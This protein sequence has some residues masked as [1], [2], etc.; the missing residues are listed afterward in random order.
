MNL[1]IKVARLFLFLSLVFNIPLY[2]FPRGFSVK[3]VAGMGGAAGSLLAAGLM[4]I[5]E[6]IKSDRA[7]KNQSEANLLSDI[8]NYRMAKEALDDQ[9][10][11]GVF[12]GIGGTLFVIALLLAIDRVDPKYDLGP[13]S[14]GLGNV[15]LGQDCLQKDQ[16][17]IAKA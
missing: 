12:C 3:A 2:S 16:Q 7:A 15:N 5:A 4:S 17:V 14:T 6:N 13:M 10:A 1:P 9:Y 8:I 11:W